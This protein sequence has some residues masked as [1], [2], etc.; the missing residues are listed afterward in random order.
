MRIPVDRIKRVTLGPDFR[1]WKDLLRDRR[2]PA[3]TAVG[4]G[5]GAL[6]GGMPVLGAHTW[7]AAGIGAV[8]PVPPLAVLVGSNVSN[9]VTFV[10][11]T[12]L[13]I[14]V[15]QALLARPGGFGG[16]EL[17]LET[18]AQYWLEAWVGYLVVGPVLGLL[19]A[20]ALRTALVLRGR[21]R[22]R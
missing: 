19:T 16:Q 15:G 6:I 18:V 7:I 9:P 20:G 3:R 17:T 8:L 14:R 4:A 13:E 21:S 12:W 22:P 5:L 1:S 11:I 10:P 2:R